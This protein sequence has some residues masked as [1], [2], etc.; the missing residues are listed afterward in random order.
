MSQTEHRITQLEDELREVKAKLVQAERKNETLM[1]QEDLEKLNKRQEIFINVM[2]IL[3]LEEDVPKGMNTVL[4][5]IGKYTNVSRVQIW[6][7]NTDGITYGCSYEWCNEKES[8]EP[9]IHF[10]QNLPL[11]YGKPWFELLS[12]QNMICTSDIYSLAQ[13]I[14]E[15]LERQYVKAIVVLPMS[16]YGSHFGFITFTNC[17][18][19]VW[20]DK[21]IELLKNISQVFSNIIRRRQVETAITLSQETMKTVL[22]NINANIFVTE[23]DSLKILFANN[24]FR[25]EVGMDVE[26][27][28]CWDSLNAG[29]SKPCN[30]CPRSLLLDNTGRPTTIHRWEDYNSVTKRWYIVI[31]TAVKWVTGQ[32]AI[33]ELATDITDRKLAETELIHAKERAEESDKLKSAFLANMSHEI[34]TPLNAIV[35]FSNIL[36]LGDHEKE[37]IISYKNIIHTN[38]ELLL[39]LINNILDFSR[40]EVDK[41]KFETSNYDVVSLCQS[42]ISTVKYAKNTSAEY[43]FIS[44]VESFFI[45]TD[46][47]R[48]QQILLNLLSNAAKFTSEGTITLKLE[49]EEEKN[50]VLF[51]VTDTGCGIPEDKQDIIFERFEKLNEYVQGTGLGLSI[52]KLTVNKLG[53]EIWVD[54]DYRNG[55]RFVFSHPIG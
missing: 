16:I 25:N 39:N 31:S 51:S 1:R 44:P 23:Y 48:L 38:T 40:L 5:I 34:R 36:T 19:K 21:E 2:Q 37:D 8:I 43:I 45:N 20:E 18:D 12:A 27:K 17:T 47:N 10:C 22:D 54:P 35:G 7:N 42:T 49:I 9:V 46:D 15:M 50:R 13:P 30:N 26:G 14:Y 55:A 29:L 6:E 53:G 28:F 24:N 32:M 11:E 33:M 3:Q 41:V 4:D 52:C